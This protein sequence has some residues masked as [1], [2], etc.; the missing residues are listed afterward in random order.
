MCE[1]VRACILQALHHHPSLCRGRLC[2]ARSA[3]ALPRVHIRHPCRHGLVHIS[4]LAP[5]RVEAVEDVVREGER[6]KVKV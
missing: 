5:Q 2:A 4:Q 1:C 6:V 3:L